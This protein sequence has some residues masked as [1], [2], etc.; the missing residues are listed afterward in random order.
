MCCVYKFKSLDQ[1]FLQ[2]CYSYST[3]TNRK[4]MSVCVPAWTKMPEDFGKGSVMKGR[5]STRNPELCV[6]P[7]KYSQF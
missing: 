4:L 2:D 6:N 3:L 7:S 1:Q 5:I